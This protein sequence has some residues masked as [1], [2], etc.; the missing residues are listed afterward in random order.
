VEDAVDPRLTGL[1]GARYQS[2]PQTREEAMTLVH[3]L[4]GG[5][6]DQPNGESRWVTA[7]AGG[8]RTVT[9]ERL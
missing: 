1:R 7:I 9:L 6:G 3:L 2:P 5:D 8:R 4:V